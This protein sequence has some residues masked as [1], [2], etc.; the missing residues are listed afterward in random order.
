MQ[1]S[2]S[3]SRQADGPARQHSGG[4]AE[5]ERARS[6]CFGGCD[7]GTTS[8]GGGDGGISNG[9]AAATGAKKGD[10]GGPSIEAMSLSVEV[11]PDHCPAFLRVA[12]GPA[13]I[14]WSAGLRRGSHRNELLTCRCRQSRS[15]AFDHLELCL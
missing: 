11:R 10:T 9:D 15:L 14:I 8:D 3:L 7:A 13:W 4:N 2:S 12:G 5:P 6:G 1:A